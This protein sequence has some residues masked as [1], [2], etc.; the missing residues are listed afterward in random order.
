MVLKEEKRHERKV[1][2]SE[3]G[4][5]SSSLE[6]LVPTVPDAGENR[7]LSCFKSHSVVF[8]LSQLK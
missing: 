8:C 5:H 3:E 2:M 1:V 4:K 6:H 7:R